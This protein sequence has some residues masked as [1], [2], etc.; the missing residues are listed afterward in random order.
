KPACRRLRAISDGRTNLRQSWVP[1]STQRSTCSAT[2]TPSRSDLSVRLRVD[3]K[4]LRHPASPGLPTDPPALPS[5]GD[6]RVDRSI[7]CGMIF[8]QSGRPIISPSY[9]DDPTLSP[10]MDS[11]NFQ[12]NFSGD[13]MTLHARR[14]LPLKTCTYCQSCASDR[15][16]EPAGSGLCANE[17]VDIVVVGHNTATAESP[18]A[19]ADHAAGAADPAS[20]LQ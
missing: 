11:S 2:P 4:H 19:A 18:I 10:T 1:G 3:L 12:T 15:P 13:T 5:G 7:G 6:E 20:T 17:F 14:W 9:L 8:S 16:C